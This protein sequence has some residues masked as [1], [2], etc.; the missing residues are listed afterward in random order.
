MNV[1]QVVNAMVDQTFHG[2]C[3]DDLSCT[4]AVAA[5]FEAILCFP[6]SQERSICSSLE[7]IVFC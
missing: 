7:V 5:I 6:S 2:R 4:E 3:T 1:V